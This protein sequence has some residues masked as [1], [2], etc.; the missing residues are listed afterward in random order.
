LSKPRTGESARTTTKVSKEGE[1]LLKSDESVEV[2]DMD[3]FS[4]PETPK[5]RTKSNSICTHHSIYIRLFPRSDAASP[6]HSQGPTQ[7]RVIDLYKYRCPQVTTPPESPSWAFITR[8]PRAED[9]LSPSKDPACHLA[10]IGL[11]A[12][13]T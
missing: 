3:I 10:K 2:E 11:E 13:F 8:K 12:S 4:Q 5:N 6:L 9:R 1:R 7:R